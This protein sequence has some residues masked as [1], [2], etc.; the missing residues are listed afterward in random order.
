MEDEYNEKPATFNEMLS[1]LRKVVGFTDDDYLFPL[2]AEL[3]TALQTGS[4]PSFLVVQ[5]L[6]GP[7]QKKYEELSDEERRI[8]RGKL[9]AVL[10]SELASL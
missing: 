1:A 9:Q 4:H 7:S 6:D 10:H 8:L 2:C 5:P 3:R